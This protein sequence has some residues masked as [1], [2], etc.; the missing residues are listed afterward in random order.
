[1]NRP[2]DFSCSVT[3]FSPTPSGSTFQYHVEL[4]YGLTTWEV[5]KRFS[6]FDKLLDQLDGQ[7]YGCLPKLPPKT[8]A[9]PLDVESATERQRLLQILL[10]ELL[11]R[12]DLRCSLPVKDFLE[13]STSRKIQIVTAC[14]C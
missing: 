5:V 12:P 8:L 13:V 2:V 11:R 4:S 1:M 6:D 14:S 9:R 3:K 7:R 10:H